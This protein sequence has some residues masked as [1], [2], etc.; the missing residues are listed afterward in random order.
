VA[1]SER[2]QEVR[3]RL[4]DA[5]V[6]LIVERGWAAVST[7]AVAERAGLTAGLVH[8]HFGSV[9]ALLSRAAIGAMRRTAADL[10]PVLAGVDD[11]AGLAEALVASSDA[12]S[13]TDPVSVLFVETYLA[14]TR[15]PELRAGVAEVITDFRREL[16]TRLGELGV[17]E[18]ED[19]ATVL[20]AAM[21][22]LV[23]QRALDPTLP[24]GA[25]RP[26]IRR[27]LVTTGQEEDDG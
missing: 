8:Y 21:D 3:Q 14:A 4:L 16:A 24:A 11:A 1:S 9:Q 15:D 6:E 10:G 26:V 19:T 18:P 25:V 13:G 12:Y 22:G 5:A 27:L 2:G 17:A 20:G 23:L 7:R